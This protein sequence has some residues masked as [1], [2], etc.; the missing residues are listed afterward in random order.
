MNSGGSNNNNSYIESTTPNMWYDN[1]TP[2][3]GFP[4]MYNL[5]FNSAS[6]FR[7]VYNNNGEAF[8]Y[9]LGYQQPRVP[10]LF[11]TF[12]RKLKQMQLHHLQNQTNNC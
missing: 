8:C 12:L 10:F 6:F 9:G 2:Q 1:N 11:Q 7:E 4:V 5:H 3:M